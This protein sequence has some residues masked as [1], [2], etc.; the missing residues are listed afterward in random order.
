VTHGDE[1]SVY[2]YVYGVLSAADGVRVS[3]GGV[4]EAE[5]RIVEHAGLA[6]L[7]STLQA[8]ALA[9]AREVRAH[10][11]VLEEASKSATVIPVRFGTVMDGDTAVRERLLEPNAERLTELLRELAGRVQLNVKGDYDEERLLREIVRGSRSIATLRERVGRLPDAAGYY[12]RIRMGELVAA[13]VGKRRQQDE[14]LALTRLEPHA[15]AATA[16]PVASEGGAFKLAF[17][18]ESGA[19]D[20]FSQA[21]G[22][23]RDELGERVTLR[24]VGPLP[25]YSFADTDLSAEAEAWA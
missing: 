17:L 9:A 3:A 19:L 16:E 10:W 23:L 1:P 8:D 4:A 6:A 25:P 14:A 2:V 22:S 24:Y 12:D 11:R 18:V 21:V 13:E 15:V 7:V 20:S 5:V